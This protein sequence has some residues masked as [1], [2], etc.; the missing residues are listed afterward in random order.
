MR[1]PNGQRK[2]WLGRSGALNLSVV[3]HRAR[4]FLTL[5]VRDPFTLCACRR[6][7]IFLPSPHEPSDTQ[8]NSTP[9]DFG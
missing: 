3:N 6:R 5:T 2:L 7:A 8:H 9:A 4:N 1:S